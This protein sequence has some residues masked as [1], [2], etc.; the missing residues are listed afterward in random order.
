MQTSEV[1]V[2]AVATE[3]VGDYERYVDA[4]EPG[5]ALAADT[6]SREELFEFVESELAARCPAAVADAGPASTA[7]LVLAAVDAFACRDW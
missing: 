3:A 6:M 5:L 4:R 2:Y 7:K 1:I